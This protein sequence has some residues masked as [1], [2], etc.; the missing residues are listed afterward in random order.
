MGW[1]S[2]HSEA[3]AAAPGRSRVALEAIVDGAC[4]AAATWASMRRRSS[5]V[6]RRPRTSTES[7]RV[8]LRMSASGSASSAT[9]SAIFPAWTVPDSCCRCR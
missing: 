1:Q 5:A 8:V 3:V 9:R 7:I 6:I 4:A 2:A